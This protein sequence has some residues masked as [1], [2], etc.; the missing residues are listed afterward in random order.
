MD[1]LKAWLTLTVALGLSAGANAQT[2][3][4]ASFSNG[5]QT[6]V[7]SSD[8]LLPGAGQ[9]NPPGADS[10]RLWSDEGDDWDWGYPCQ[11]CLSITAEALFLEINRA[12][13]RTLV[14]HDVTQ[15][16]LMSTDALNPGMVGGPRLTLRRTLPSGRMFEASYFGLHEWDTNAAVIGGSVLSLPAPLGPATQDFAASSIMTASL[17]SRI[18]NAEFNLVCPTSCC[19]FS[20]LGGFRYFNLD[21]RFNLNSED[22]LDGTSDYRIGTDSHLYGGQ[23]GANLKRRWSHLELEFLGKV[24]VFGADTRQRTFLGD[25]NNTSILRDLRVQSGQA[26]FIGELGFNGTLHITETLFCRAGYNLIWVDG[27]ARA[28]DQLDFTNTA[29]SSTAL[30]TGSAFFHGVNV[31]LEARW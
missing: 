7:A 28:T 11:P 10:D 20:I 25:N 14:V 6:V 31:G 26:A 21:E 3:S 23:V 15:D 17:T 13:N 5:S 29:L 8:S 4:Y 30:H 19:G 22:V 2:G 12:G 16:P 9:E 18:H 27:V 1:I 24:G